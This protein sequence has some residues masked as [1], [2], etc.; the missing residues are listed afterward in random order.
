MT[1]SKCTR[2][3]KIELTNEEWFCQLSTEEK[4]KWLYDHYVNAR[5]EEFYG[6]PEKTLCDYQKWLVDVHKGIDGT[7][8]G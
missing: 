6:R 3:Y 5:A 7:R 2:P 8:V 4:A 1:E